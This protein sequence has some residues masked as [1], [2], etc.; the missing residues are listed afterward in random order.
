MMPLRSVRC[1]HMLSTW[2][3]SDHP[4]HA[5]NCRHAQRTIEHSSQVCRVETTLTTQ[6]VPRADSA[7]STVS[8]PVPPRCAIPTTTRSP[9][10]ELHAAPAAQLAAPAPWTTDGTGPASRAQ[11]VAVDQACGAHRGQCE[12]RIAPRYPACKVQHSQHARCSEG[13]GGLTQTCRHQQRARRS[14]TT[15]R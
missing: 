3:T 11:P 5:A 1:S 10:F 14:C 15:W 6:V 8:A 12:R 2:C 9:R 13:E 7:R 4:R